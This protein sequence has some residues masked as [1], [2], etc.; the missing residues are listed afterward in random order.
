MTLSRV[1]GLRDHIYLGDRRVRIEERQ[2]T[3]R[4][5]VREPG[6]AHAEQVPVVAEFPRPPQHPPASFSTQKPV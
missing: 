1:R 2:G 5:E 4:P 6:V 3:N